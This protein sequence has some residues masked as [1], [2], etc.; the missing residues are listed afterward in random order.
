MIAKDPATDLT[1]IK[2]GAPYR[3][4]LPGAVTGILAAGGQ[5]PAIADS[6]MNAEKCMEEADLAQGN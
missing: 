5:H 6:K 3:G 4:A 1:S 2:F